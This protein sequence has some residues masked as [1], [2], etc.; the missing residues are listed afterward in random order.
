MNGQTEKNCH[1]FSVKQRRGMSIN[2]VRDVDSFDEG[3]IIMNTELGEMTVEGSGL[4][5]GVLDTDRGVVTLEG[6]IDAIFYSSDEAQVKRGLF[7]RFI[8]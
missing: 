5:I 2:G 1:E 7:S 3:S 4:K 8:K 6:K